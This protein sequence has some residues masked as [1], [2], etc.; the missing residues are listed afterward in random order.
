MTP[1]YFLLSWGHTWRG[2]SDSLW[3][4]LEACPTTLAEPHACASWAPLC[5]SQVCGGLLWP[6]VTYHPAPTVTPQAL[7]KHPDPAHMRVS[8]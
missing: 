3:W 7:A 8:L 1:G 6:L 2:P 4:V 5:P